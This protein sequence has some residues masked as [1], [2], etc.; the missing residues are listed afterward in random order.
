MKNKLINYISH[1]YVH[2]SL[3]RIYTSFIQILI[4]ILITVI[5]FNKFST[6]KT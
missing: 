2:L 1:I 3:I 6:Y 4:N 5:Y